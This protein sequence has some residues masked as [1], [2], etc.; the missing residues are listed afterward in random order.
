[1]G[2]IAIGGVLGCVFLFAEAALTG[3]VS[4]MWIPAWLALGLT[5]IRELV[6]DIEDME[7]DRQHGAY[8]FP[9]VFGVKRSLQLTYILIILFCL[10]WWLP[11]LW[12][13]YGIIYAIPLFLLVEIPLI[14]SIF[15]LWKNPTSSGCAIISRATKWITLGG[16]ITILCSKF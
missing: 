1:L 5:L 14:F 2:N 13:S 7:G 16:M 10:I 8:T 9:A 6:K 15:F 4:T 12:G 3:R 11:Y